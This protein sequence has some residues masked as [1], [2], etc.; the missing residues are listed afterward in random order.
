MV[1]LGCELREKEGEGV[2]DVGEIRREEESTGEEDENEDEEV[3]G[4]GRR[5]LAGKRMRVTAG[6]VGMAWR[7]KLGVARR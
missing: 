3:K 6:I 2:E 4:G 1:E 5:V 7:F